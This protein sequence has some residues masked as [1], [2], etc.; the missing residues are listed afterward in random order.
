MVQVTIG[1]RNFVVHRLQVGKLNNHMKLV[2]F[3]FFDAVLKF[4]INSL[5]QAKKKRQK[6]FI[7]SSET[8][9]PCRVSFL[10]FTSLQLI[11]EQ[12][13]MLTNKFSLRHEK[14]KETKDMISLTLS[15]NNEKS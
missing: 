1:K 3:L 13:L 12:K 5:P 10:S 14:S 6:P 9:F 7:E 8:T 2:C 11:A 4:S 15:K